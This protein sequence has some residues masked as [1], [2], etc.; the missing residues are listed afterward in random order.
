MHKLGSGE[1]VSF[2]D[3]GNLLV[4]ILVP[5]SCFLNKIVVLGLKSLLGNIVASV[6]IAD[7]VESAIGLWEASV[8]SIHTRS[9][10]RSVAASSRESVSGSVS[11]ENIV[12][13][14]FSSSFQ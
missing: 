1:N 9:E 5:G 14:Q 8:S 10:A 13:L 2:N 7:I 4:L 3:G 11:F 6:A 12:P